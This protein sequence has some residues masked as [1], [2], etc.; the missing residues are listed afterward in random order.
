MIDILLNIVISVILVVL[1]SNNTYILFGALLLQ[2]FIVNKSWKLP[3]IFY[4]I[5]GFGGA[6]LESI[7]IKYGTKTWKYIEPTE[8]L[9]VPIW[10]VPLWAITSAAI[11]KFSR[12]F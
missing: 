7:A 4:F 10:L 5:F 1:L 11:I 3:L 2:I 8:L 6:I 12:E 9:N